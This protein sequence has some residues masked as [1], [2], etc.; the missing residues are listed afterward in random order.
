MIRRGLCGGVAERSNATDCKSVGETLRWFESS[1]LHH[2]ATERLRE[3]LMTVQGVSVLR[4][5]IARALYA[6]WSF[7]ARG[8]LLRKRLRGGGLTGRRAVALAWCPVRLS[9]EMLHHSATE[10]LREALMTVQGVSVLHSKI[11]RALVRGTVNSFQTGFR[12]ERQSV[13]RRPRLCLG[14]LR[15]AHPMLRALEP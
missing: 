4:R 6:V 2:S 3:A 13:S 1:P 15:L 7:R 5:K 12:N 14:R 11:P 9:F 8:S 10:R